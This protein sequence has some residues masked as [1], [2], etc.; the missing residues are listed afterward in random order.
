MIGIKRKPAFRLGVGT[1]LATAGFLL[2]VIAGCADDIPPATPLDG[3]GGTPQALEDPMP[4]A[5]E[6]SHIIV[7]AVHFVRAP[8]TSDPAKPAL[9]NDA[10]AR[11]QAL[12]PFPD[13]SGRLALTDLRGRIYV[14]NED[15]A[16]PTVY[17]DL[18]RQDVGFHNG[19]FPNEAGLLGI[20]FHPQFGVLGAPGRG[21]LYTAFSAD[22]ASGEADYLET[23][24]NVQ[25]SVIREWT[26]TDPASM[27]FSG[28]SREFLRVGQFA[29]MHNIGTIAFNPTV[30][31]GDED[32]GLLYVGFGDGGGANDPQG[33]GQNPF[34]PLGAV[35]RIDPLASGGAIRYGIPPDNPFADGADGLPEVW[36]Y[37]FRHPQHFSWGPQGAL[38]ISD[39]GQ[40]QIEEVNIGE[41]GANY[42]WPLREGT[43]ATAMGGGGAEVGSVYPRADDPTPLRYPVAQYDHDEG[44]AI[45]GGFVY[46]GS[47]MPALRG[48]FV[49]AEVARGRLFHID[50]AE[51]QPGVPVSVRELRVRVD[52]MEGGLAEVAGHADSYR[53]GTVRVD[54]RLGQ[55]SKGELYMLTKGDGRVRKLV[56]PGDA[57]PGDVD[58]GSPP[59]G[60]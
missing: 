4:A 20:A 53:P 44:Y 9:T 60:Q 27:T 59:P 21:K 8:R 45:S 11:I 10:H 30:R 7:D 35:L 38:F 13:G 46:T 15:G 32:F 6:K 34:T 29:P 49:F 2:C 36:A 40:D 3:G 14:T 58:R 50:T 37:G 55:D 16:P 41:P 5:V 42:G 43:F 1:A 12:V 22:P 19:T 25:E 39:I 26:A 54:L 51:L 57:S 28:E 56:A 17:L 33:H 24:E 23:P 48:K 52:G 18:T 31:E 47:A